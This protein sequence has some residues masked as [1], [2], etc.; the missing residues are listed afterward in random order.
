MPHKLIGFLY[1]KILTPITLLEYKIE[2]KNV[3]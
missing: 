3:V 1:V 2:P